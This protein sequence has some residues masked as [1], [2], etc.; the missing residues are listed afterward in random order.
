MQNFISLIK[1][2]KHENIQILATLIKENRNDEGICTI[3]AN[4]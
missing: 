4:V 2:M 3:Q 1:K